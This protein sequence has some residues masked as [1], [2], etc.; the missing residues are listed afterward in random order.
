MFLFVI[1]ATTTITV[2]FFFYVTSR[3]FSS[4]VTS[5]KTS[6]LGWLTNSKI[7]GTIEKKGKINIID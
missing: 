1:G 7:S 5:F 4:H 6:L 3:K 2:H